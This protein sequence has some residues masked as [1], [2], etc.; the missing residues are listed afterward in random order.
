MED[1]KQ[2]SKDASKEE[3]ATVQISM[4]IPKLALEAMAVKGK[5]WGMNGAA[6]L[7]QQVLLSAMGGDVMFRLG[8]V[9]EDLLKREAPV[10][11]AQTE[12]SLEA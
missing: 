4:T 1:I 2:A 3:E 12:L 11:P 6:W 7:K 10:A 5:P 9:V 8:P